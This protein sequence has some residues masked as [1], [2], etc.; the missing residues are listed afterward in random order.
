MHKLLQVKEEAEFLRAELD[1]Y[2]HL[3]QSDRKAV[4]QEFLTYSKQLGPEDL[5]LEKTPPTLRDF[6]REIQVLHTL[7]SEV[8]YLDDVIILH[9]WLQ[10]DLRPFTAS[11]LSVILDWKHMYTD[12]L[13]ESASK[14]LQQEIQPV[15]DDDEMSS[16]FPLMETILLLEAAGVELPE[17]LAAQLKC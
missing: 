2:S 11:L 12:F 16:S 9:G 8:T 14:S 6:Q 15:G 7:S 10:V 4:F 17:H 5:E 13:L 3:W 1:R